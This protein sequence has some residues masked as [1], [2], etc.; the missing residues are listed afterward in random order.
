[1]SSASCPIPRCPTD[2]DLDRAF[3]RERLV[4]STWMDGPPPRVAGLP[5]SLSSQLEDPLDTSRLFAIGRVVTA[6]NLKNGRR[7]GRSVPEFALRLPEVISKLH[8]VGGRTTV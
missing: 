7:L 4:V 2:E 8:R 6:D 1:M 5:P 3:D